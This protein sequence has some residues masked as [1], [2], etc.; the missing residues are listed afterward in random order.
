MR[1]YSKN[2]FPVKFNLKTTP[3]PKQLQ[4]NIKFL[5]YTNKKF[6]PF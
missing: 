3:K 2:N 5:K 4:D 6:K 1:T